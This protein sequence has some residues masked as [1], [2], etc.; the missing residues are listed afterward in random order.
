MGEFRF[1]QNLSNFRYSLQ[2][3]V[4]RECVTLRKLLEFKL[5]I[6]QRIWLMCLIVYSKGEKNL[7]LLDT[8][9]SKIAKIERYYFQKK[10]LNYE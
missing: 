3:I 9:A 6:R 1:W 4:A 7:R 5:T 2:D 8:Y 10:L